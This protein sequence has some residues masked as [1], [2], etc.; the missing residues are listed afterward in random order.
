[1]FKIRGPS[2]GK[3]KNLC[4]VCQVTPTSSQICNEVQKLCPWKGAG[5]IIFFKMNAQIYIYNYIF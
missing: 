3:K 2:D 5:M 1:M 4:L